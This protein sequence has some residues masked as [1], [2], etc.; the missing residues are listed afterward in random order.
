MIRLRENIDLK[1]M[2]TFGLPAKCGRLIEYDDYRKDLPELDREGLL[3]DAII[4]GGGSNL[5]IASDVSDR[6]F[7]RSTQAEIQRYNWLDHVSLSVTA[8]AR[9]DDVCA[10]AADN[11]LWGIE[12]LS[13]IPGDVGGATVQ[14]VG[15]YGVELKGVVESVEC[16]SPRDHK[17]IT[18]PAEKCRYGYRDSIFKH[19]PKE[20]RLI[21]STTSLRL[22]QKP[23]VNLSYKGL[24]AAI[25]NR[26]GLQEVEDCFLG[27]TLEETPGITPHL[28]RDAIINIRDSKLPS[29][30]IIGSA[31]SFFKNPVIDYRE[32]IRLTTKWRKISGDPLAEIP[33]H[34]IKDW[35]LQPIDWLQK[36]SAAWLIDKAGCKKLKCGGASLW[37]NQPLVLVNATG[38]A[39]AQDVIFLE[40]AI[41]EHVQD[42]FGI[43]LTPE[44][45]HI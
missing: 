11:N 40:Q 23:T 43:T 42:V 6:T 37:Q 44:V 2:T 30:A 35:S 38:N 15:A 28:L 24:M 5:L 10:Y 3:R 14:N 22:T 31:G 39:T 26:L 8:G 13:G 19:L 25:K 12:N 32:S 33:M 7:I 34:A 36:L 41:I 4:I 21:V 17:F 45:I 1:E 16:Y 20:D 27:R 18:L 9:L 29:P